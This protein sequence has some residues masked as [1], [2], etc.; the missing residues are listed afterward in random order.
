[1]RPQQGDTGIAR[2]AY[3]AALHTHDAIVIGGG[4]A[5][6]VAA[7]ALASRGWRVTLL[8]RGARGRSKCCGHC[9]HPRAFELLEPLGCAES[10][11]RVCGGSTRRGEVWVVDN[12]SVRQVADEPFERGGVMVTREA[13]DDALLDAARGHG[14]DVR[15][16]VHA[17]IE[18]GLFRVHVADEVVDAPL[19]V[20]ADGLGS[21][22]ARHAGLASSVV[23]RKF[24]F[25]VDV[26]TTPDHPWRRDAIVMLVARGGYLGVVGTGSGVHLAACMSTNSALPTRP[27]ES[28]AW[29]VD[30]VPM[31][32]DALGDA[33]LDR[34]GVISAVGPMPWTTVQRT[35]EHVAL[36]GDAAGYVE[37][38]TGEGMTWAIATGAA[39][40]ASVTAPGVWNLSARA[41]Y[42]TAWTAI[43]QRDHFRCRAVALAVEHPRFISALERVGSL[44][45]WLRHRVMHTLVP[46]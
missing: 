7:I 39:L 18:R 40:G 4:P 38:F 41:R 22:V 25:A 6:S 23:G 26:A 17:R 13:L 45:P 44:A 43:A 34:L 11:R 28:I 42:E 20:G 31:L 3:A 37:P 46:R 14:V 16:G 1:L 27:R 33:W 9:L 2:D 12:L 36:V 5:G 32:R 29:F 19:V 35:S 10:V 24:G 8:D 30:R 15:Q 21:A